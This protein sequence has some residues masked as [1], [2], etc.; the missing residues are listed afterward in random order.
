MS[1]TLQ[2]LTPRTGTPSSPFPAAGQD[3]T[4]LATIVSILPTSHEA[5]GRMLS[6]CL[7]RHL[8]RHEQKS[9]A[10]HKV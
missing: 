7:A 5:M 9:H 2:N 8:T 10:D 4:R 1:Y 3:R 6:Q